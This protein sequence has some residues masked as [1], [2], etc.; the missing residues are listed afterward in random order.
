MKQINAWIRLLRPHQWIKNGFVFVG[1]LFGRHWSDSELVT[2]VVLAALAFCMFSSSVYIFNDICDLKQDRSHPYK[3]NRPLASGV[4]TGLPAAAIAILLLLVAVLL[5]FQVSYSVLGLL[6]VYFFLN[7]AYSLKLKQIV[8]VDVFIIA[9]GFILRILVGTIGVGIPTSRW[10]LLCGL[11]VSLFL[12]FVKRRAELN[13]LQQ[14]EASQHTRKVLI[15]YSPVLLDKFITL[16]ASATII[17]YSLYTVDPLTIATQGTAN[18]IYTVPFVLYAIFRYL[19]LL[20]IHH[21]GE[22]PSK[23]LIRDRHIFFAALAWFVL[24]LLLIYK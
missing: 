2:H 3:S 14:Q 1:L 15:H 11:M 13:V 23:D 20:H 19:Y 10:L 4:I 6:F 24:T 5:A 7:L 16:T 9:S 17:C 8:I 22:D 21:S 12:G 18:L